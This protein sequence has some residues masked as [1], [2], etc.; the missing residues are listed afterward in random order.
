MDIDSESALIEVKGILLQL[1]DTSNEL[2]AKANDIK[3]R[4]STMEEMWSGRKLNK[5]VQ[6]QMKELAVGEISFTC[7]ITT[8]IVKLCNS[9][10]M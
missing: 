1:L 9:C 3:R 2:G 10:I 4:I 8:C 5:Q 7:F 6:A